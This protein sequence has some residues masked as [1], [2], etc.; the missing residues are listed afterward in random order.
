MKQPAYLTSST[1][2]KPAR[3]SWVVCWI[4]ARGE[5]KESPAFGDRSRAVEYQKDLGNGVGSE[6]RRLNPVGLDGLPGE[7]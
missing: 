4:T 2:W 7:E 1:A 6:I 5:I 3:E